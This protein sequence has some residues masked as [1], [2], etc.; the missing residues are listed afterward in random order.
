MDTDSARGIGPRTGIDTDTDMVR[1]ME[2]DMN[3]DMGT[4]T[5]HGQIDMDIGIT[6]KYLLSV[7]RQLRW[8]TEANGWAVSAA[9]SHHPTACV[10]HSRGL[11]RH[12]DFI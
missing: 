9:C 2:M 1:D 12:L 5:R 10:E 3:T 8:R 4:D 7:T 6:L 11:Y